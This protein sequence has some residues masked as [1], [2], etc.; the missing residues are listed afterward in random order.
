MDVDRNNAVKRK[1]DEAERGE[2]AGGRSSSRR[3]EMES[4]AHAW[5]GLHRESWTVAF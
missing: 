2:A 1:A 4:S 5:G 3:K